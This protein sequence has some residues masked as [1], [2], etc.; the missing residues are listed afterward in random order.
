MCG[1]IMGT[2]MLLPELML[3]DITYVFKHYQLVEVELCIY[4]HVNYA[5]ISLDNDLAPVQHQ[6]IIC[7]NAVV[8]GP[9]EEIPVK[10]ESRYH[11][12]NTRKR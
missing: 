9:W 6:C 3:K 10:L 2:V 4:T 7:I 5:T 8:L 12:F 11:S 1:E